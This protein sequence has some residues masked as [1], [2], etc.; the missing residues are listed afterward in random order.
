MKYLDLILLAMPL[1]CCA[2]CKGQAMTRYIDPTHGEVSAKELPTA[3]ADKIT[4][5]D[6]LKTYTNF[7]L[8]AGIGLYFYMQDATYRNIVN[9]NFDEVTLDYNMKHGAMVNSKGE[10]DFTNVDACL[11]TLQANGLTIYGHCLVWHQNQNAF[12]LNSLIAP[13]TTTGLAGTNL[14][15][16]GD[17]EGNL[18]GW[19]KWNGPDGCMVQASGTNTYHGIGS[20]KVVNPTDNAGEQWKVQIHSDF[21]S[22]L[23]AG[24]TYTVSFFVRSESSGYIRCSTSGASAH[25]QGDQATTSTWQK[26]SWDF[27]SNGAETGLN[28][29]LGLKA[30]T[31]YIDN[32]QATPKSSTPSGEACMTLEKTTDEKAAILKNAMEA[33]IKAMMG[34][35]GGKVKAWDVLNE[36]MEE[37]GAVRTDYAATT[38]DIFPWMKYLGKDYGVYAFKYARQYG[39]S[40]NLLF[41]NDYNLEYSLDKCDGLIEYVKYIESKG[42]TIDGI[43]TQMHI[44]ITTDSTKIDKMF[45]K[46]AA[47]GKLIKVSELDIKVNNASPT[48]AILAL[49]SAMYQYVVKSYMKYVPAAQRYGITAWGISDSAKEHAFWIPNDA[50]CLWNKDYQRKHSYKGFADGLAGKDV[51]LELPREI[52]IP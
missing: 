10:I 34:H 26:V 40:D 4:K 43:G 31:Y 21:T 12:Y 24:T 42:A 8:G 9:D 29:D 33:W 37:N 46:L 36:P 16:N 25:Y 27:T 14:L 19:T 15:T 11:A 41:V 17:F 45:Q 7:K 32:I 5:Y 51:S 44:S 38:S 50:P 18:N 22:T 6:K 28:L 2:S 39:S 47:T 13:T 35:Y 23:T 3:L 30:G 48:T 20:L 1:M 52:Q 49:Q